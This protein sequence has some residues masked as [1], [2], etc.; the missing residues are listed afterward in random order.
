MT[1][2]TASQLREDV[3]T[4]INRVALEGE[5]IV[6]RQNRKDVAALVSMEDLALIERIE[7]RLDFED[8]EK[9]LAKMQADGEKPILWDEAK[10]QL[11]LT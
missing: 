9:A 2:L 10:K 3:T 8:A 5:R 6:L 4:A 7:D 1:H 11:G